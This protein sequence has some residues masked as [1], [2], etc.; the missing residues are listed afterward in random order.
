[1]TSPTTYLSSAA[2]GA[3][4]AVSAAV[5][6]GY[7][8]SHNPVFDWLIEVFAKTGFD[9]AFRIA[10][11]SHD[12][13][14]ST[15]IAIPFAALVSILIPKNAWK[16]LWV[17]LATFT[18]LINWSAFVAP[19]DFVHV[20]RLWSFYMGTLV[21]VCSVPLAYCIVLTVKSRKNVA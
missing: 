19:Q 3:V 20:L 14:V 18:I 17:A 8:P 13:F 7:F 5:F 15:I 21:T 2:I 12:L 4:H 10:L 11:Y 16:H 1:M 9:V 6:W